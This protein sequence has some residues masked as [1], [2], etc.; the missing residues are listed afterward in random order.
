LTVKFDFGLLVEVRY[1]LELKAMIRLPKRNSLVSET[2]TTIKQWI[3]SGVLND[4][5]PGEMELK[6]R[7]RVG[8]DTVRLALQAL[9]SEGWLEKAGQGRQ[10][11]I[12]L[13]KLPKRIKRPA[14]E[15]PVTV[16][17]PYPQDQGQT[18]AEMEDT[19]KRLAE[20]QRDL[21]YVWPDIFRLKDPD[22]VL[23]NLVQ[24]HRSAAWILYA[25]SYPV[26]RW[27]AK[28]G[29]PTLISGWPYPGID[30]PY[31]TKCWEPAAFHAGLQF[32]RHGHHHIGMFE[33]VERGAGS[34]LIENGLRRALTTT[35]PGVR[36]S[37]FKDDRTPESVARAYDA[38]FR[39]KDRPTAMVLT[40]SN[41]LLTSLSWLVSKGIRVPEDISWVVF[42]FDVWY[43]EFFPPLCHYKLN[44]KTFSQ[45]LAERMLELVEYGRVFRKPL[46]VP[47]EFVPGA[48]IGPPPPKSFVREFKSNLLVPNPFAA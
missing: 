41:H 14:P 16:L 29:L 35:D 7:L 6:E 39:M 15:L 21:Q 37:L 32:I 45:G 20:M 36:L 47:V 27:F 28:S 23:E 31:V 12:C 2:A 24:S 34:M 18:E 13:T 44:T 38:A 25:S 10:R 5:L 26:Q 22:A 9:A 40:S 30:L 19:R 43:A 1:T 48:T 11:R 3:A 4:V 33:F 17:S 8:R 42:P 46:E